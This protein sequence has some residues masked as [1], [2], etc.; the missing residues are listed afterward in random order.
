M[1]FG[2]SSDLVTSAWTVGGLDGLAIVK[3]AV[4]KTLISNL[5]ALRIMFRTLRE[6]LGR[7]RREAQ[8][9]AL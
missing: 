9:K 6:L 2:S 4:L 5:H 3:L 8:T 1:G 7:S